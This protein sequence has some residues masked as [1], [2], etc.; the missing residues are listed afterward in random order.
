MTYINKENKKN[1]DELLV[2]YNEL[3][4]KF[5]NLNLKKMKIKLIEQTQFLVLKKTKNIIIT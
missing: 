1:F 3:L 5:N 4:V 2:R